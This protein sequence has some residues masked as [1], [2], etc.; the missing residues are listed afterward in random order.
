LAL[1]TSSGDAIDLAF[2]V[3]GLRKIPDGPPGQ[4]RHG[5]LS[6]RRIV[7]SGADLAR[8][9]HPAGVC[10]LSAQLGLAVR[11]CAIW[12]TRCN[13]HAGVA[14]DLLELFHLRSI[15]SA[16]PASRTRVAAEAPIRKRIHGALSARAE[17]WMRTRILGSS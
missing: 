3:R 16:R 7:S 5:R 6:Y 9:G 8:G 14:R 1:E 13:R 17:P 15:R 12:P 11:G 10:R 2:T 4:R